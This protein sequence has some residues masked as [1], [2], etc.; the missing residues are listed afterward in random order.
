MVKILITGGAGFVGSHLCEELSR[1]LSNEITVLD[2]YSTGLE[3]NHID[4]VNYIKGDTKDI[5][6]L[7]KVSPDI[8]YHLGEYSRVEQ[9]FEDIELVSQSNMI[10]TF[11]VL[12]FCRKHGSKLIY[13]E[14]V[15]NLVTMV[16]EETKAHMDGA[17][18]L[19]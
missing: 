9:S 2:N 19:M 3:E 18:P 10:G 6:N 15:Q 14:A 8:V 4:G 11:Q 12:L 1:D 16:R 17:K 5:D 13:A 7:V